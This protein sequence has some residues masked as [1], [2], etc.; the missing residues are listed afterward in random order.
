MGMTM[1]NFVNK[2]N[3][4]TLET[5]EDVLKYDKALE[6]AI[7]SELPEDISVVFDEYDKSP[8]TFVAILH[9]GEN[10]ALFFYHIPINTPLNL[11]FTM[12][13]EFDN[14]TIPQCPTLCTLSNHVGAQHLLPLSNF[15]KRVDEIFNYIERFE[16]YHDVDNEVI[17]DDFDLE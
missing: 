7:V 2:Y 1:W 14:R 9:K 10:S 12:P 13:L 6:K 4:K 15:K 5:T 17:N 3:D 8:M 11:N 16:S